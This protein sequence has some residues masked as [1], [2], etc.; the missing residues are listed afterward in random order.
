MAKIKI[1]PTGEWFHVSGNTEDEVREEF[2]RLK[3]ENPGKTSGHEIEEI[4]L[5]L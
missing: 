1:R 3:R 4:R 5:D 2:S